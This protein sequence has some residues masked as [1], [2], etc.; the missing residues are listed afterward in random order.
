MAADS[1]KPK[2]G[3]NKLAAVLTGSRAK[4]IEP[5]GA[6]RLP[7]YGALH[8][9]RERVMEELDQLIKQRLLKKTGDL[10][11]PVLELSARG[12]EE[13]RNLKQLAAEKPPAPQTPEPEIEETPLA[14]D[15][16]PPLSDPYL[17]NARVRGTKAAVEKVL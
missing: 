1:V 2:L 5:L 17:S 8:L 16:P 14:A 13:L 10:Q 3:R 9:S 4:W 12:K 11:Y 7:V 6:H 15:R